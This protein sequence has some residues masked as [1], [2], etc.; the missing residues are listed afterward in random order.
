MHRIHKI[1]LQK[2]LVKSSVLSSVAAGFVAFILLLAISSYQMMSINDEIMD[3]ITD[4]LL[5]T[6]LSDHTGT[7]IDGLSDEFEIAYQLIHQDHLLTASKDFPDHKEMAK[8]AQLDS[9][10]SYIWFEHGLWRIYK[11]YEDDP[12]FYALAMQPLSF[13]F[14]ELLQSISLYLF[15]L[16]LLWFLQWAFVHFAIKKHFSN[17]HGLSNKIAKRDAEHLE[18]I[19]QEPVQ[20]VELQPIVAQL[21]QLLLKLK[22][23]MLAEQRFTA[24]ASHELRSPLSAMQM[25][26][27][28]L[29]RKYQQY[30]DLQ[31]DIK[32]IQ[33]DMNR[34]QHILENLLLLARLDPTG[35]PKLPKS[36]VNLYNVTMEAFKSLQPFM[37]QKRLS[38]S[39]QDQQ[40]HIVANQ[41]LIYTCIRNILDNA[42]RYEN[43]DGHIV[44]SFH[45]TADQVEV[46]IE[47]SGT[48]LTAQ[49][50]EHLGERFYRALGTKTSG[51]GLGLSICK[52]IMELHQGHII[53]QSSV[54][55][56]GLKVVLSLPRSSLCDVAEM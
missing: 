53:F 32:Q 27:Q 37:T 11:N 25:R 12:Q 17:I 21:N 20:I 39:I 31:Y 13:R 34:S 19:V 45:I 6:D 44:V 54:S 5:T 47:D 28:L 51:S 35:S 22:A 15:A 29:Q 30:P 38:Y 26:L 9:G 8:L 14:E 56:G 16:I 18:P 42:I 2:Q 4:V 48:Q 23:S 10:Y 40:L 50:L 33:T 36:T 3:E 24:D 1:S 46:C 49:V 55:Y 41:E 7:Q 43:E 52:K